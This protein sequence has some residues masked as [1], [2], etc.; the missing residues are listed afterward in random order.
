MFDLH[1]EIKFWSPLRLFAYPLTPGA[2]CQNHIFW[3]FWRF[4]R[5]LWTKLA[6]I[7]SKRNLQH[8]HGYLSTS[9]V[10]HHIFAQTSAEIKIWRFFGRES[11]IHIC[12][13]AFQLLLFLN[14]SPSIFPLFFLFCF[15]D[16]PSTGLTSSSKNSEKASSRQAIST[17]EQPRVVAGNF[18]LIFSLNFLSIF[19]PI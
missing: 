2:F 10:F 13:W 6:P 14:F 16:W 5:W 3:T 19:V 9:I 12:L 4:S 18:S 1:W 11:D 8:D 15:S 17:M 7:Y